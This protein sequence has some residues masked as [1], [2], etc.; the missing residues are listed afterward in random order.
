M[1]T[2]GYTYN[3][4]KFK[5]STE[6]ITRYVIQ[7]YKAWVYIVE[8]MSDVNIPDT[9]IPDIPDKDGRDDYKI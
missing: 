7:K 6:I 9:I 1:S 4:S 3:R 2:C 5:A 8:E